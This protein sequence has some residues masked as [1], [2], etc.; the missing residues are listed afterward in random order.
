MATTTLN[1]ATAAEI[2]AEQARQQLSNRQLASLA[3]LEQS[4][5]ARKV[6]GRRPITVDELASISAGLGLKAA[7]LIARAEAAG[8]D[9]TALAGASKEVA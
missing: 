2:R 4:N 8:I 6:K 3:G 1:A 9:A 7:D 5:V